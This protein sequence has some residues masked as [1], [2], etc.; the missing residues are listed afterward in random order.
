[1]NA[2]QLFIQGQHPEYPHVTQLEYL[3][4]ATNICDSNDSDHANG[5]TVFPI[6]RGRW[7]ERTKIRLVDDAHQRKWIT[8]STAE[9]FHLN[10][11]E[12]QLIVD[13][14]V[15]I[16]QALICIDLG[17]V[18]L[19]PKPDDHHSTTSRVAA[20]TCSPCKISINIIYI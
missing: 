12:Y 10:N 7:I 20:L 17:D 19:E 11:Y 14:N 6:V 5:K 2:M 13:S 4:N 9:K 18:Y 16:V 1:M 15:V 3:L 8:L